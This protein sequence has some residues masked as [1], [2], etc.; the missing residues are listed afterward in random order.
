MMV[1][2]A[3][4]LFESPSDDLS[5][6]ALFDHGW[7]GEHRVDA[8]LAHPAV[9]A[10]LAEQKSN[11]REQCEL[12]IGASAHEEALEPTTVTIEVVAG[13]ASDWSSS[14]P[15]LCLRDA[16]SL[17]RQPFEIYVEDGSSDRAFLRK[18]MTRTSWA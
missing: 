7:Q 8:D 16:R 12:A 15:R 5:L 3:S 18:M 14:P 10:W 17:L 4:D 9:V 6:L 2:L 13:V 11:V 1:R